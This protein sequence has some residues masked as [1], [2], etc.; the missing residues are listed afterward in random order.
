VI[1]LNGNAICD[2]HI[3]EFDTL[4]PSAGQTDLVEVDKGTY[5]SVTKCYVP[6]CD[7]YIP[8]FGKRWTSGN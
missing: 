1:R 6:G 2:P 5:R 3:Q 8:P 4:T 7:N